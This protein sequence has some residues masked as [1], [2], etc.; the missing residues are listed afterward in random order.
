MAKI[1]SDEN[2][3]EENVL[4]ENVNKKTKTGSF[5]DRFVYECSSF[6]LVRNVF[7]VPV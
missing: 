3:E 2:V 1:T 7:T 6:R 5:I 4:E